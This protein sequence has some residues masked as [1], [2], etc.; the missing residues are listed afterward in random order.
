MLRG[1]KKYLQ[2]LQQSLS[3][4]SCGSNTTF[5]LVPYAFYLKKLHHLK[6]PEVPSIANP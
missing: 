2:R 5:L 1:L 6:T 4:D 3:G